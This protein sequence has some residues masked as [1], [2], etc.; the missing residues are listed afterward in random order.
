MY[1]Y[2]GFNRRKESQQNKKS[3]NTL[4]HPP[5]PLARGDEKETDSIMEAFL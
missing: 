5:A 4:F 3:T 2:K 1:N